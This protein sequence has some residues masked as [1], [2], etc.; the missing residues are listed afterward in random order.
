M[1]TM[2]K[3]I[4]IL[5]AAVAVLPLS[6]NANS[7]TFKRKLLGNVEVNTIFEDDRGYHVGASIWNSGNLYPATSLLYHIS[8]EGE[9][10]EEFNMGALGVIEQVVDVEKSPY[11]VF[12]DTVTLVSNVWDQAA[13]VNYDRKKKIDPVYRRPRVRLYGETCVD[14]KFKEVIKFKEPLVIAGKKTSYL[15]V[16]ACERKK[17]VDEK[18]FLVTKRGWVVLLDELFTVVGE[19]EFEGFSG[20][21][22]VTYATDDIV[23]DSNYFAFLA[24]QGAKNAQFTLVIS[25]Y[26]FKKFDGAGAVNSFGLTPN[27]A[28]A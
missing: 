12:M 17:M 4:S 20:F 5:I 18:N 14:S 19:N 26:Q 22:A 28:I 3:T 13:I 9:L 10:L 24:R 6:V 11:L 23:L 2:V 16:G 7:W 8:P 27:D 21:S 15:A 1:R 25:H